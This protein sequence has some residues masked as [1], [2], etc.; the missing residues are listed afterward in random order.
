MLTL[1]LGKT[2]SC[3]SWQQ[4]CYA[5]AES[6]GFVSNT[7]GFFG[8]DQKSEIANVCGHFSTPALPALPCYSLIFPGEWT[9]LGH[10]DIVVP[11]LTTS[12]YNPHEW[13]SSILRAFLLR[14]LGLAD[15]GRLPT[16]PCPDANIPEN[17]T[18]PVSVIFEICGKR[19]I[20]V[21]NFQ[22]YRAR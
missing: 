20:Q 4:C 15:A 12:I 16:A 22:E 17:S 10:Q 13:L 18:G 5:F 14:F 19:G 8:I 2:E 3:A 9:L 11:Q 21:W 6:E 7:Q 1:A